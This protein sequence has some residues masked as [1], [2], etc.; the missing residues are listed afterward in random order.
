[1]RNEPRNVGVIAWAPGKVAARFV[2]E[3]RQNDLDLRRV[4]TQLISDR[5]TYGDWV[6][7]YRRHIDAGKV[8]DPIEHATFTVKDEAFLNALASATRGNYELRL[9]AE[10]YLPQGLQLEAAVREAFDRFVEPSAYAAEPPPQDE[11]GASH[12]QLAHDAYLALRKNRY[13]EQQDFIRH[14]R[15]T[16][17]TRAGAEVPAVFD[18]GILP[19][20]PGGLFPP[21]RRVLVD[22]V[23]FVA[24][25]EETSEVIDRAR[26][27]AA[28]ATEVRKADPDSV[29][30]AL[31]SNGRTANSEVGRW[32][33]RVL[34]DEGGLSAITLPQLVELLPR[35]R[36]GQI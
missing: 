14:Y 24:R 33:S 25:E 16:G 17:Q 6:T 18:L 11:K 36:E 13:Q 32:A 15:V 30:H 7:F 1:V 20:S 21:G 34:E 22:A 29:V 26:A 27:V 35:V 3:G 2:G 23:S 4:S 9:G 8:E 5:Q 10:A 28:K 12:R 31:V 19:A